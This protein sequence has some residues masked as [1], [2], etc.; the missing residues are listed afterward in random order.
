M[1]RL[2]C[3]ILLHDD[4]IHTHYKVDDNM[5]FQGECV[6]RCRRCKRQEIIKFNC[7]T[8]DTVYETMSG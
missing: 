3:L 6:V 1:R 5:P 2:L 8:G 4:V 7:I